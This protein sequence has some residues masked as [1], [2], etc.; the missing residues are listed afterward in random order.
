ERCAAALPCRWPRIAIAIGRGALAE[1]AGH[2]VTAEGFFQEALQLHDGLE[3]PIQK[4]ETLHQYGAFLRRSG[5]PSRARSV[6]KDALRLAEDVGAHWLA[7]H[8]HRELAS[9]GGRRRRREE[10]D[11][12]TPAE[13]RGGGLAR[14]RGTEK[15]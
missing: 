1:P 15:R 4:V 6:L 11:R 14:G 3:L 13:R 12:P 9:A 10:P 7:N 8:V 5:Q 2:R